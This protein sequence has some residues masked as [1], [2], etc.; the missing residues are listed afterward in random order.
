MK[1]NKEDFIEQYI[2]YITEMQ[3]AMSKNNYRTNNKYALKLN[4]L[5]E[6][7]KNEDYYE[8]ALNE[9]MDNNN[10]KI[11]SNAAVES[12]RNNCNID[13][14]IKVLKEISNREDAGIEGIKAGMALKIWLEKGIE[15][16]F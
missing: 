8:N 2:Y 7:Y 16:K 11:S 15:R 6:K 9:L 13:K 4:K 12:F 1:L 10:F 14:A 5:N 3:K